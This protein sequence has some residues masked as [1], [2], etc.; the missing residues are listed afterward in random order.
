MYSKKA[1][2]EAKRRA[3]IIACIKK[4]F[5]KIIIKVTDFY[6][7]FSKTRGFGVLGP[8]PRRRRKK[9][10]STRVTESW[11]QGLL[12]AMVLEWCGCHS[13]ATTCRLR[14]CTNTRMP[15]RCIQAEC[16]PQ[17]FPCSGTLRGNQILVRTEPS[18]ISRWIRHT[19]C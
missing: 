1:L 19:K 3:M 18:V 5:E 2:A 10:C 14:A 15:H 16:F 13:L 4:F 7:I 6:F 12:S 8:P 17:H 9:Y 11:A